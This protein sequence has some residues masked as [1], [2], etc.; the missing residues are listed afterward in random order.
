MPW[1]LVSPFG[2]IAVPPSTAVFHISSC[3][4]NRSVT[5]RSVGSQSIDS[6]DSSIGRSRVASSTRAVRSTISPTSHR[7][8]STMR[9][10]TSMVVL[11]VVGGRRSP[12]GG[13]KC[14]PLA[15]S[16]SWLGAGRRR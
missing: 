16:S 13:W 15:P 8:W 4:T 3:D 6:T 5:L 1:L 11:L 2:G 9:V 14:T 12:P 10:R 7:W